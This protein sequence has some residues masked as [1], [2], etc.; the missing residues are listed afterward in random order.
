MG[1]LR[2]SVS[3]PIHRLIPSGRSGRDCPDPGKPTA[4]ETRAPRDLS[5]ESRYH[6]GHDARRKLS[7]RKVWTIFPDT[8]EFGLGLWISRRVHGPADTVFARRF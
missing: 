8:R 1:R 6:G 7:V 5:I 3:F 2:E 4:F